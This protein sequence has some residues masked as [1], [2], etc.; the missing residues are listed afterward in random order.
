LKAK[1]KAS[2]ERK[3][4]MAKKLIVTA[5]VMGIVST[6]AF[7]ASAADIYSKGTDREPCGQ[8]T[9]EVTKLAETLQAKNNDSTFAVGKNL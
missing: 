3:Q 5:M 6:G 1:N 7:S 2:N 9:M 4:E 8:Y